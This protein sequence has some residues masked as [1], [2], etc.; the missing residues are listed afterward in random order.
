MAQSRRGGPQNNFRLKPLEGQLVL[1]RNAIR[2]LLKR[3]PERM[4]ELYAAS[5][6]QAAALESE[7]F[8]PIRRAG[9]PV[10]KVSRQDMDNLAGT[11]SHQ[12]FVARVRDRV[13]R[14]LKTEIE[15]FEQNDRALVLLLDA[16]QDPQNVGALLRSAEC[17]G[18]NL[19]IWSKNRGSGITPVVTKASAGASELVPLC[20]VSNA[21]D[22]TRKLKEAGFWIVI[23]EVGAESVNLANFEWPAKS[24]LILGS[25]GDGVSPILQK[26][27]DY[28]VTI[29]MQGSIDSLN[30]GQ[31]AAVLLFSWVNK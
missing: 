26:L 21:A 6:E 20:P 31:A 17:F 1:G 22:A 3:S 4:L 19:V 13:Y 9:I 15:R 11:A 5:Y 8:E 7:I 27:A 30:V 12:G 23:G 2:E 24:V 10:H 16:I 18:V 28:R 29:P 25:E 14:D